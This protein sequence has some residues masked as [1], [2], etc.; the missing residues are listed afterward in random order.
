M[1]ASDS[2]RQYSRRGFS[3][4]ELL[5][6]L[7]FTS[8]LMA[9]MFKIFQ[10][11]TSTFATAAETLGIQRDARWGLNLL[12]EEVLQAGFLLPPYTT[13]LINPTSSTAQPPLMMQ[14][15][16]YTPT[17]ATAPVDELQMIVDMP[18]NLSGTLTKDTAI[19]DTTLNVSLPAGSADIKEGDVLLM[20]DSNWELFTINAADASAGTVTIEPESPSAPLQDAY[21]NQLQPFRHESVQFAHRSTG[22]FAIYRPMTVVRY[23][24]VPRKLDPSDPTATVPCLVRQRRPLKTDPNSIWNPDLDTPQTTSP[25]DEQILLQGVTGF[26]VDWSFDGGKT[27]IRA[28][29]SGDDWDSIRSTVDKILT[30]STSPVVLQSKGVSN[31]DDPYWVRYTPIIIR[32][33]VTTRTRLKRTEY[34]ANLDPS[35]P[36]A[37]YRTRTETLMLSPRNFALGA[38]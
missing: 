9:G 7:V 18:M 32:I 25:A 17:D 28:A 35:N 3:L 12:Q 15:T 22:E 27:F 33:D 24:V 2:F 26:R 34:T 16:A 38:N 23:T 8:L 6:A 36:V 19:G 10:A 30:T 14:K 4:V 37:S 1:S 11:S 13:P 21:G 20:Q 5:V 31:L 29:G